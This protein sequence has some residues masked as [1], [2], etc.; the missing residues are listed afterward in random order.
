MSTRDNSWGRGKIYTERQ[1][2]RSAGWGTHCPHLS[3][4]CS[5]HPQPGPG[6]P[7]GSG[8]MG[9]D[10]GHV[11]HGTARSPF[12]RSRRRAGAA[13]G[14][15]G[16]RGGGSVP[17]WSPKGGSAPGWSAVPIPGPS[18]GPPQPA[19]PGSQ[20]SLL[21]WGL[22]TLWV[23]SEALA[24]WLTSPGHPESSSLTIMRCVL[25]ECKSI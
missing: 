21:R 25:G 22:P 18:S 9:G 13:R 20:P 24:S 4:Q 15:V 7:C 8:A 10:L 5:R 23:I 12:Q 2:G 6:S 17:R 1:A 19:P 14:T 3:G 11:P 16:T